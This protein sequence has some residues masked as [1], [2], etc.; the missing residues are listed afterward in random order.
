MDFCR[1]KQLPSGPS[2]AYTSW[3]SQYPDLLPASNLLSVSPVTGPNQKEPPFR[4]HVEGQME[5]IQLRSSSCFPS[6]YLEILKTS[7][8]YTYT[9]TPEP[10]DYTHTHTHTHIYTHTPLP[11]ATVCSSSVQPPACF[12]PVTEDRCLS[13]CVVLHPHPKTRVACL[14]SLTCHDT[15]RPQPLEVGVRAK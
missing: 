11:G 10:L 14:Q 13:T 12:L 5:N 6:Y 7:R 2:Q 8:F 1:G 4:W 3:R 15:P 9:H